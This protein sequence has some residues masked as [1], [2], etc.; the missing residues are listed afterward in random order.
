LIG[1]TAQPSADGL[2]TASSPPFLRSLIGV[3]AQPSTDG[4]ATASSPPFLRSLIGVT[5]RTAQNGRMPTTDLVTGAFGFTGSRIAER[6]LADGRRVRTLSRRRAADHPLTDRVERLAYDF[7]PDRLRAALIDVDTLYITYW[8]RFS[9]RGTTFDRL[10]D[11]IRAMTTAAAETAVR[12]VVYVSVS[13]AHQAA[14]T[15]YFR[16]KAR[17]EE[18]VRAAPVSHAIVRPTLLYGEGDILINNMAWTLRRMPVFGVPGDGRYGVQPVYVEDVADLAVELGARDGAVEI[19]AAGPETFAFD[20]L[21]R[22]VARAVGS[23]ALLIHMPPALVL[24]TTRLMGLLLRDVV[25]TRDEI[26]ELMHSLLVSAEPAR[27]STRFSDWLIRRRDRIGR[28]YSSELG[29]NF[30]L[31]AA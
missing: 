26:T 2:A 20:D 8:M 12:R 23:R 13:N 21:V 28:R 1:V 5:D 22:A 16:A 19:D 15:D 14:P 31:P 25:L 6:L 18:V 11:N 24:S 27:C 17:A 9:R 29:R 30:R 4:L 10:V 3:T 7:S